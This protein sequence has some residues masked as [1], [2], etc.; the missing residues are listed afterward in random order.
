MTKDERQQAIRD[1]LRAVEPG[2]PVWKAVLL[3]VDSYRDSAEAQA[4]QAG[5]ANDQRNYWAGAEAHMINLKN[6]LES[7]RVKAQK[8]EE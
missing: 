4:L 6:G 2:H 1:G 7:A 5:I 8:A 3:L